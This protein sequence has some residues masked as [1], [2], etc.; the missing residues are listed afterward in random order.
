MSTEFFKRLHKSRTEDDFKK[1]LKKAKTDD[2]KAVIELTTKIMSKKIP[3]SK[4]YVKIIMDNRHRLRHLVHPKYSIK[5]KK[6]Y[7]RQHGG[8]LSNLLK[9]VA[10]V[11]TPILKVVAKSPIL[12]R[13][14]SAASKA[15]LFLKGGGVGGSTASLAKAGSSLSLMPKVR[16][17]A[18]VPQMI[19]KGAGKI[20]QG[21]N[22]SLKPVKLAKKR[23]KRYIKEHSDPNKKNMIM[24]GATGGD[25]DKTTKMFKAA[26]K[27]GAGEA[28]KFQAAGPHTIPSTSSAVQ[29][30][31]LPG[32]KLFPDAKASQVI[33][34]SGRM[35]EKI[36]RN[37]V[38][39][40][41]NPAQ[42][43]TEPF[44]KTQSTLNLFEQPTATSSTM[45]LG[46]FRTPRGDASEQTGSTHSLFRGTARPP[47]ISADPYKGTAYS[48]YQK[49][50]PP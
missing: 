10:K 13:V 42:L 38:Y 45:N 3:L 39:K 48:I 17:S 36:T 33:T 4:K 7:L 46:G 28:A 14:T 24:I 21:I 29:F 11:A 18:R 47:K 35:Y 20:L 43:K 37:Q 40:L 23:V 44:H 30:E 9:S 1:V 15:S 50:A 31:H 16:L 32:L 34:G 12:P 27:I 49:R 22:Y 19:D 41:A 8:S 26:P 5:S 2:V 25:V 6:R